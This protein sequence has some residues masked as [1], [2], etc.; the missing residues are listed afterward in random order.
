[1]TVIYLSDA[2]KSRV[3]N[4]RA[5]SANSTAVV[6]DILQR[7]NQKSLLASNSMHTQSPAD[8]RKPV[9]YSPSS[10]WSLEHT[11]RGLEYAHCGW[12]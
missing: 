5:S 2:K 12:F 6:D 11:S 4:S 8:S 9:N 3:E 10:S 7:S 1:M